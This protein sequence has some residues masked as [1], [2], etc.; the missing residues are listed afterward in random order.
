MGWPPF[1][2]DLSEPH[3]A[4]IQSCLAA[5]LAGIEPPPDARMLAVLRGLRP[6][7]QIAERLWG[8]ADTDPVGG[9]SPER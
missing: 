2:A 1:L 4:L 8:R 6:Y 5:R 9:E 7:Q 3:R